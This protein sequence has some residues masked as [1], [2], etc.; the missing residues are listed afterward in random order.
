[1]PLALPAG[2]TGDRLVHHPL[3]RMAPAPRGA[4]A[5]TR[6]G[7]NKVFF[8]FWPFPFCSPQWCMASH[9]CKVL[10]SEADHLGY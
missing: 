1:M 10:G 7:L 8:P 6:L 3:S 5:G 4:S 2:S 9:P